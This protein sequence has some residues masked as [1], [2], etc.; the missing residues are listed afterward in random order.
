M[1]GASSMAMSAVSSLLFLE[2]RDYTR[3][4]YEAL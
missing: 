1:E 3:K 4:F 2:K